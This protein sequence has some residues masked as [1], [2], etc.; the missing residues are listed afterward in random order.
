MN[1]STRNEKQDALKRNPAKIIGRSPEPT[2][3]AES[4]WRMNRGAA[5][6]TDGSDDIRSVRGVTQSQAL[7]SLRSYKRLGF[8][9]HVA[10]RAHT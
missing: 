1:V 5:A 8:A 7:T 9:A 4:D 6:P 2:S 3:K 10:D